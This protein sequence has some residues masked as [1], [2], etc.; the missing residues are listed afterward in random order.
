[1]RRILILVALAGGI[2]A[3]PQPSRAQD[4]EEVKKLKEKLQFLEM[5]LELSQKENELLK[6]ENELLKK[7]PPLGRTTGGGGGG[8]DVKKDEIKYEMDYLE[9]TFGIKFK[10]AKLEQKKPGGDTLITITLEFTRDLPERGSLG[11]PGAAATPGALT[12]RNLFTGK[13]TSGIVQTG[14]AQLQCYLFDEN[15][16]VFVKQPPGKIE[17]EVSGKE[18]DAFRIS[19]IVPS[20]AFA[21]V[22]KISFREESSA[23]KIGP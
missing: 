8:E 5:K 1:M 7:E 15:G 18:G 17:G 19:Q 12:L 4:S 11:G 20:A 14:P 9:K 3:L 23:K 2:L 21:K 13:P 10:A 22:K 16:V 6:K